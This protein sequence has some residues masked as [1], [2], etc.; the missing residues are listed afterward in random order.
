M[1]VGV[2]LVRPKGDT[3]N[4]LEATEKMK[5]F[6]CLPDDLIPVPYTRDN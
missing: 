5:E 3:D 4:W 6:H 2:S 1:A